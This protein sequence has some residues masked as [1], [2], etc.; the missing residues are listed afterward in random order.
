MVFKKDNRIIPLSTPNVLCN[1]SVPDIRCDP[2]P[3]EDNGMKFHLLVLLVVVEQGEHCHQLLL[4]PTVLNHCQQKVSSFCSELKWDLY[5]MSFEFQIL[6]PLIL[7]QHA[8]LNLQEDD[9]ILH[10]WGSYLFGIFLERLHKIDK[11]I[12]AE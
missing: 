8:T 5:V 7:N 1:H 3:S 12:L 2:L 6:L 9:S 11:R 10:I 4:C